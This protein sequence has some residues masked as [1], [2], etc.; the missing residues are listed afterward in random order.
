VDAYV[1]KGGDVSDTDGRRC[2]CNGL[3]ANIGHAQRRVDGDEQPLITSGDHLLSLGA[4][5]GDR[6]RYSASDVIDHLLAEALEEVVGAEVSPVPR[7]TRFQPAK[8]A[9]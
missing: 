3:M 8:G 6:E 5:L 2:L 4:F 1:A 7:E 9:D